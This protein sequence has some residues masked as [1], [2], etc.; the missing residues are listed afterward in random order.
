MA[1]RKAYEHLKTDDH[2]LND[3]KFLDHPDS[4]C[5]LFL[6]QSVKAS[7]HN[8][9]V[10]GLGPVCMF[11][12]HKKRSNIWITLKFSIKISIW[13]QFSTFWQNPIW[14]MNSKLYTDGCGKI[15]GI[16]AHYRVLMDEKKSIRN[17]YSKSFCKKSLNWGLDRRKKEPSISLKM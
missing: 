11:A 14:F 2:T 4:A 10:D 6:V 7:K 8:M 3:Q 17:Y 5:P 15:F 16:H 13:N 12:L 9:E 1:L